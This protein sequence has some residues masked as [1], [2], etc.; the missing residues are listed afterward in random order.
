MDIGTTSR[1]RR[2]HINIRSEPFRPSCGRESRWFGLNFR[3]SLVF[4]KIFF[5]DIV[6]SR[7]VQIWQTMMLG[8][9]IAGSIALGIASLSFFYRHNIGF[10]LIISQFLLFDGLKN[11]VVYLIWHP[12][13]NIIVITFL[14]LCCNWIMAVL[15]NTALI[16]LGLNRGVSFSLNLIV[17]SGSNI[18]FILIFTMPMYSVL[19]HSSAL[20]FYAFIASVF[21]I[22]YMSRFI[23]AMRITNQTSS[24]KALVSIVVIIFAFWGSIGLLF[25]KQYQTFNYV[26]MYLKTVTLQFD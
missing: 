9:T 23:M 22:W 10:D 20:P 11:L 14:I 25:E 6:K 15:H 8:F 24:T 7:N 2:W 17:W 3:R 5:E 19:Q 13:T 16:F 21:I 12:I 18:V 4:S 26:S 1:P